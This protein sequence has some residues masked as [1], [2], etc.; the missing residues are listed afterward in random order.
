MLA[1]RGVEPKGLGDPADFAQRIVNA[2]FTEISAA[3]ERLLAEWQ[4]RYD[5]KSAP[6]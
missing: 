6:R 1:V 2:N 5:G 3:R 4:R